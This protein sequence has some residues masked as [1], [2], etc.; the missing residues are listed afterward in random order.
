MP[1]DACVLGAYPAMAG[2]NLLRTAPAFSVS[3]A[4]RDAVGVRPLPALYLDDQ[5]LLVEAEA[6]QTLTRGGTSS[7]ERSPRGF[8]TGHTCWERHDIW[9]A[10]APGVIAGRGRLGVLQEIRGV[11][12]G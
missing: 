3:Q 8:A 6:A 1:G 10:L 4:P 11:A 12:N 9:A 2:S 7:T 5:V